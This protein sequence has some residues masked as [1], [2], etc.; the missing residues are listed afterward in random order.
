MPPTRSPHCKRGKH[1]FVEKPLAVNAGGARAGRGCSGDRA[2]P[3]GHYLAVGFNRRFSAPFRDIAAFFEGRR[4]PLCDH[5]PRQRRA[6][7]HTDSWIQAE[8]Q[9][10]RIVG[11]GC[12]FI[13]VFA[14]L[15]RCATGAGLR[16][17]RL[18]G[19]ALAIVDEDTC[20]RRS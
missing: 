11:E 6:G 8:G 4:E 9:G 15:T 20:E 1:V 2:Q 17:P 3:N 14:S 10:G 5:V 18:L 13:D 12:H 7:F 19:R 16:R